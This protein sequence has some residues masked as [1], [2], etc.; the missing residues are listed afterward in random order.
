MKAQWFSQDARHAP[1]SQGASVI[2]TQSKSRERGFRRRILM[3]FANGTSP[4]AILTGRAAL[5]T[6]EGVAL[7]LNTLCKTLVMALLFALPLV[8]HHSLGTYDSTN[9]VTITGTV[10]KLDWRNPHVNV[11]L[12][13]KSDDGKVITQLIQIAAVGHLIQLGI[14]KELF[15]I[16]ATV[17]FETL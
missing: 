17:T 11:Y 4:R 9:P 12:S 7:A 1:L 16:G 3:E 13:V 8:A 6:Q 15:A 2:E 5:L 10:T 14:A